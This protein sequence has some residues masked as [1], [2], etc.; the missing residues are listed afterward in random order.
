MFIVKYDATYSTP[1][2][3]NWLISISSLIRNRNK[4][5]E[6]YVPFDCDTLFRLNPTY[7]I[8]HNL[9]DIDRYELEQFEITLPLSDLVQIN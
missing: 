9:Y 1:S 2:E 5:L 3:N 7:G 4:Y 8:L 6:F